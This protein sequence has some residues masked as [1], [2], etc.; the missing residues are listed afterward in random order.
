MS[1]VNNI[2]F[3][4]VSKDPL[5]EGLSA[6]RDECSVGHPAQSIV[7][8][9]HFTARSRLQEQV[10]GTAL[11]ARASIEK[12]VL[13]RVHRL[14]GLPSSKLGLE[15][16]TGE[17]DEFSPESYIPSLDERLDVMCDQHLQMEQKM[18]LNK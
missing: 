2:S 3:S 11:V 13:G 5:K 7:P 6:H 15:S 8:E 14:P 17:L 18:G 9:Q 16:L 10:Y 4:T 1:T 12:Q